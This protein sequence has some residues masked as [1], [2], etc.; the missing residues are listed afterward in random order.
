MLECWKQMLETNFSI[1]NL[2][3]EQGQEIFSLHKR[4]YSMRS[5]YTYYHQAGKKYY[6]I[7]VRIFI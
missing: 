6:N 5:H 4:F 3:V 7:Y 2:K 1:L